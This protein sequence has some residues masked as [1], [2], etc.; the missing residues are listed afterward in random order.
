MINAPGTAGTET[1]PDPEKEP[2]GTP[3]LP[4]I[5]ECIFLAQTLT[6]YG[7][8]LGKLLIRPTIWRGFITVAR[9][10][11]TVD[12]MEI[13]PRIQRGLMRAMALEAMLLQRAQRGRDMV[14]NAPPAPTATP[15]TQ[16]A[17][18]LSPRKTA[19]P[20]LT[21]ANMPSM[22]DIENQV[23]R[24]PVGRTIAAICLDLAIS[25]SLCTGPF[26]QRLFQAMMFFNGNVTKVVIEFGRRDERFEADEP[27]R[28]HLPWPERT[29]EGI[30]Q[31]LGGSFIGEDLPGLFQP[32]P[33]ATA[34]P[35]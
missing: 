16:A 20:P 2:A 3:L 31:A 17:R 24:T 8:Y 7:H 35:S 9:F 15:P 23:R 19:Q 29:R 34:G 10:F 1:S 12:L 11:G 4:G 5:T 18:S 28:T 22:S 32:A 14:V 26:W 27:K 21:F 13:L 6:A 30:R 33:A 25:P